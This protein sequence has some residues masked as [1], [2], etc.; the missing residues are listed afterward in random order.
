MQNQSALRENLSQL[1]Q[2]G[3]WRKE[4]RKRYHASD[5]TDEQVSKKDEEMYFTQ[6]VEEVN[7][8]N[9]LLNWK[10]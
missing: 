9:L 2:T 7:L 3:W 5:M 4:E 10:N 8:F 1:E 6:P